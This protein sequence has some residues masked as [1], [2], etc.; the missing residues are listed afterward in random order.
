MNGT[1][2]AAEGA[3]QAEQKLGCRRQ[4]TVRSSSLLF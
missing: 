3:V 1:K 4:E 2:R